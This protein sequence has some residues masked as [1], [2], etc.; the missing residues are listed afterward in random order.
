MGLE[1]KTD[2]LTVSRNVTLTWQTKREENRTEQNE[3]DMRLDSG[4]QKKNQQTENSAKQS[5]EQ[6]ITPGDDS[7]RTEDSEDRGL[8]QGSWVIVIVTVIVVKL[9]NRPII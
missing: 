9:S 3:A 8:S 4:E 2:W 5:W 7:Q 6:K 1:T